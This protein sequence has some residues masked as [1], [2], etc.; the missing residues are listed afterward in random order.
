MKDKIKTL[1]CLVIA[2]LANSSSSSGG[3][4]RTWGGTGAKTASWGMTWDGSSNVYVVGGYTNTVD[5]DPGPATNNHTSNGNRDAFISKFGSDGTWLW[6]KTWGSSNDDRANSVAVYGSNVYVAGCFQDTVDFNPAGGGTLSA[7]RGTNGFPNNDAYLCKYDVNGNFKWARNWGGNG[8]DEAYHASVDGAGNVYVNGDFSS[9]NMSLTT[10]GLTG[11]VTNNGFFD[12]FIFKF[13]ANGT[14]LWARCWGGPCYDDCTCCAVDPA[15]TVYGGGM[16]ASPLADFDPGPA[17][18]YLYAHN[19]STDPYTFLGLVDVFLTK[20]DANGNFQWARS[21]GA[22]N[23][24][25]AAGGIA[26]DETDNVYVSGYFEDTVDFNQTGVASNITSHGKADAFICKHSSKGTFQW[27]RTWGGTGTDSAGGIA[28]DGLGSVYVAG[29][30]MSTNVDFDTGSGV[31]NHSTHGGQDIFLSKFDANGNFILART[32]GGSGDDTGYGGIAVDGLGN[33]FVAGDFVG[34]VDFGPLLG[35]GATNPPFYGVDDAFL[36]IISTCW[37]L[38]VVKSGNGWSSLGATSPAVQMVSL[39][40]TTQV[41]YSAADWYRILTLASNNTAIGAAA[42]LKVYT[43]ML[44]HVTADTSN[45]VTFALATTNQTGYA[46]VPTVWLTNW[47]ENAVISDSAFDV[48]GKYLI[49]L[50]PTTSNTFALKIESFDVSGSNVITVVKRTYT[51]GL[52]PD[53]MH[54]ELQLQATDNLGSVFTN[55]AGTAVTGA[56]VFDGANRKTYTNTIEGTSLF[57]RAVIQ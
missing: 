35:G 20:F 34:S 11:S 40:V 28:L 53:G 18:N 47:E 50:D 15:G 42:G 30:F 21:W 1:L 31:D 29:T 19:T 6:T 8:G 26:V 9:T 38:T 41:V 16:F 33:A 57:I 32:C 5:F 55:V 4:V 17:T 48:H 2:V 13:D 49:G 12:A 54:G 56:S 10:V 37:K 46:N 3:I 25:D 14:C 24:N 45:D 27:A 52:S 7:P 22:T 51:G 44:V 23:L 43:Q 36:A 39:G